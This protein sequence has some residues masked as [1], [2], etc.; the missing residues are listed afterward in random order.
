MG[1]A[2]VA[3]EYRELSKVLTHPERCAYLSDHVKAISGKDATRQGILDGLSWLQDCIK[4]D[5][6]GN[7]TLVIYYSGHGW[8]D[9]SVQPN[10]YYFIPYDIKEGAIK[11]R[12]LPAA[13][14]AEEVRELKCSVCWSSWM[15]CHSGG[16]GVK[17]VSLLPAGYAE[18]SI[19]PLLF[20][21]GESAQSWSKG[22]RSPGARYR[23]A[24]TQ[25]S[26][27][28]QR[29]YMRRD[30]KMSIFTYHLIEALTGHAQHR[31]ARLK[32]WSRM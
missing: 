20:V 8:R 14:F 12:A 15:F 31:K 21:E 2:D 32:C 22:F 6:S 23:R 18:A 17:D 24:C 11:S 7:A 1:F 29:S 3:K 10:Q 13:G 28:T 27:S 26:K 4:A 16:M 25:F 9:E 5:T 30:G 19:S